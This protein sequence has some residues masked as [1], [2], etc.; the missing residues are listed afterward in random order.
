MNNEG[1][2]NEKL[3]DMKRFLVLI[4]AIIPV[5]G[6]MAQSSQESKMNKFVDILVISLQELLVHLMVSIYLLLLIVHHYI[7]LQC[8]QNSRHILPRHFL[9]FYNV[10]ICFE[11][12]IHLHHFHHLFHFFKLIK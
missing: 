10:L 8:Y 12:L 7:D 3:N 9:F 2:L 5:C 1:K 4:L 6:M 11:F